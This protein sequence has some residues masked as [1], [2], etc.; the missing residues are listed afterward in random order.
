MKRSLRFGEGRL[1]RIR[2]AR[3]DCES[4]IDLL[5]QDDARKFVRHRKSR[6]RN[7]LRRA[8][9]EFSGKAF[10]IAAEENHLARGAIA[11]ITEPASELLRRKLI[12]GRVEQDQS[13]A[14]LHLQFAKRSGRGLTKLHDFDFGVVADAGDVI[15]E[16]RADFRTAR[17][18]EHDEADFHRGMAADAIKLSRTSCVSRAASCG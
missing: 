12:A 16:E 7:A 13:C 14:G 4:A 3:E 10:G 11:Q 18:P 17:F 6:E 15:V 5:R 9:A 1:F 8:G 2:M